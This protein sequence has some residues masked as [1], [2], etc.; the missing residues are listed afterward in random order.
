MIEIEI[1]VS[2]SEGREN[3]EGEKERRNKQRK[4]KLGELDVPSRDRLTSNGHLPFLYFGNNGLDCFDM[5][6]SDC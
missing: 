6:S 4:R 1:R 5:D 3:L 2:F